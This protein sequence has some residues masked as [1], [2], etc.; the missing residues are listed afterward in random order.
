M[1]SLNKI[2]NSHNILRCG[3]PSKKVLE[4]MEALIF[5]H[6]KLPGEGSKVI[7]VQW[8]H[9]EKRLYIC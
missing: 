5:F 8:L 2:I 6:G 4:I 1:L 7:Y 9:G 3:C